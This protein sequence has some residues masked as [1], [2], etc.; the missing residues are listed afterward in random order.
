MKIIIYGSQY[1]TTRRYADELGK[2]TG[3]EVKNYEEIEDVNKYD[4]IICRY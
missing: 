3:V 1:G 4:T 2:R